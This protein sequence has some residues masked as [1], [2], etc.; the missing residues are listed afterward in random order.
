MVLDDRVQ[1]SKDSVILKGIANRSPVGF[2]SLQEAYGYLHVGRN[3]KEP[4]SSIWVVYSESHYSVLFDSRPS[5]RLTP[6]APSFDLFYWDMLAKQREVIRLT[7]LTAHDNEIPDV[8]DER[9]L[10]PPLD[11]VVRTK[12][13]GAFVDWNDTE[14]IL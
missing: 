1:G 8:S 13:P 7:V 3:Y 9:A 4:Q 11:L 12:W 6:G 10:V 14:P 2:L 5:T